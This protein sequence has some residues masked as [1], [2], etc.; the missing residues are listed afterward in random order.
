[1]SRTRNF[2]RSV[3]SNGRRQPAASRTH[4]K[5]RLQPLEVRDVPATFTVTNLSDSGAGSLRQAIL[6]AS[7]AAG[8]DTIDFTINGQINLA[9]TQLPTL[10]DT[11]GATSITG[12]GASLLTVSGGYGTRVLKV[13]FGV[14]ASIS[15]ITIRNGKAL[16]N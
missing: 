1:M 6:D 9:G 10:T 16:G 14:T 3:L 12:P 2:L 8:A 15:G 4:R 11:T 7:G 13:G 5:L